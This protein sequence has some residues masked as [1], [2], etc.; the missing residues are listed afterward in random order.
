MRQIG[1]ELSLNYR[2]VKRAI[3]SETP[4]V[5]SHRKVYKSIL[6]PFKVEIGQMLES[7]QGGVMASV[8]YE[9]LSH[10]EESVSQPRYSGSYDTLWRYVRELKTRWVKKEAYLQ[11][12]TPPGYDAQCDWAEVNLRIA[13]V[14]TRVF[15]F[16]LKLSYSRYGFAKLYSVQ[17]QECFFDGHLSAFEYFGG[18]PKR[19]TYDNLKTAVFKVLKGQN[20]EEQQGFSAFRGHFPF[21]SNF[22]AV[23]KGNE[24]GKVESEIKY[25][26]NHAFSLDRVFDSIESANAHLS[27]WL[28]SDSNRVHRSHKQVIKR[29]FETEQSHL[30]PL[31]KSLPQACRLR[32]AKVNKFSFVQLETNRYSVPSQYVGQIVGIKVFSD[33]LVM[34]QAEKEIASHQRLFERYQQRIDPYHFLPLL[35]QKPRAV[36]EAVVVQA[37]GLDPVFYHLKTQLSTE[38][39]DANRQ[40]IKVLRLSEQ[41]AIDTVRDAVELAL[42]YGVC[43]YESIRN[44]VMQ[45]SVSVTQTEF[46]DCTKAHPQLAQVT[47]AIGVLSSYDQLLEMGGANH[48]K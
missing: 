35:E 37:F 34:V 20:R 33:K 3:E 13:D 26:G 46:G 25:I 41:Y 18:V 42:S 43:D 45:L 17:R 6:D 1:R 5:F 8:I 36:D 48:A 40:W 10:R 21:E 23:G 39:Q 31:P 11:L 14:E 4:A 24:K 30:S 28:L 2:T 9:K 7:T 19:V 38:V 44:L 16:V 32:Y 47:V 29:L 27:A 12:E 22:A 15:L